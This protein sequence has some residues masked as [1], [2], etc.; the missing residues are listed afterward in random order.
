MLRLKERGIY[1]NQGSGSV[2]E[3]NGSRG[4]V[5]LPPARHAEPQW[6][7]IASAR[8]WVLQQLREQGVSLVA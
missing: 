3:T 1:P 7:S 4:D 8:T 5:Y 6:A 2:A